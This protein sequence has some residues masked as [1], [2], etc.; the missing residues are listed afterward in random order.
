[1]KQWHILAECNSE[2]DFTECMYFYSNDTVIILWVFTVSFDTVL[3][4]R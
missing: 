1:M 4:L 2:D 3:T